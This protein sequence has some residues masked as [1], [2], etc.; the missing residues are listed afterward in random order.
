MKKEACAIIAILSLIVLFL[1][2]FGLPPISPLIDLLLRIIAAGS[3]QLFFLLSLPKNQLR[4]LPLLLSALLA[5]WG[6][7]LFCTSPSW[8]NATLPDLLADYCSPAFACGVTV[9]LG[10]KLS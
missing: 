10:R 1:Q 3:I 6:C 4:F 9:L 5:V 2:G 8:Q 7:W